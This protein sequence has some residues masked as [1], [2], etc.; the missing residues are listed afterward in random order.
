VVGQVLRGP[1]GHPVG[2]GFAADNRV[3]SP[4]ALTLACADASIGEALALGLGRRLP[5]YHT[6]DTRARRDAAGPRTCSPLQPHRRRQGFGESARS[7]R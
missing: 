6:T 3:G 5:L 1:Y 7:P 4:T 2:P